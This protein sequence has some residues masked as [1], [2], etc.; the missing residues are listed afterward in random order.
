MKSI[1]VDLSDDNGEK[2][3]TLHLACMHG[4]LE[5]VKYLLK[6][7]IDINAQEELAGWTPLNFACK[8]GH[9]C[10]LLFTTGKYCY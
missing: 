9:C 7:N 3:T 1:D 5:V 2:F 4:K 8:N 10:K 6:E